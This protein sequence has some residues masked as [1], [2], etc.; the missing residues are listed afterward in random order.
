MRGLWLALL[1]LLAP[2][3]AA[4]AQGPAAVPLEAL[5][6]EI[7]DRGLFEVVSGQITT[8][9]NGLGRS[10]LADAELVHS[11]T[12]IPARPG[13]SFGMI[14]R[15]HGRPRGATVRLATTIRF[16]P[17]G[18]LPP[19]QAAP[20]DEMTIEGEVRLGTDLQSAHVYTFDHE[21]EVAPGPWRFE[22]RYGDR[23]LAVQ[24]FI[25]TQES[26]LRY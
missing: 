22:V 9:P 12:A 18:L 6:V 14:Y 25:V 11:T 10:E 1:L 13:V 5:R 24:S 26:S 20:V 17:P 3:L 23:L 2:G 4:R 7:L 21:W 19:G 8:L 16:P 15:V